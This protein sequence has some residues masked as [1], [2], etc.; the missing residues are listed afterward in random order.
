MPEADAVVSVEDVIS[1]DDD[2][3]AADKVYNSLS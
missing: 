1:L 3:E 2:Q